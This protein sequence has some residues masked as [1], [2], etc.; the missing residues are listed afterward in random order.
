MSA[1]LNTRKEERKVPTKQRTVTP[2]RLQ[3][4]LLRVWAWDD[5]PCPCPFRPSLSSPVLCP[6]PC[7]SRLLSHLQKDDAPSP[8]T[9]GACLRDNGSLESKHDSNVGQHYQ[10]RATQRRRPAGASAMMTEETKVYRGKSEAGEKLGPNQTWI[11]K[12]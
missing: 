11:R 5:R 12:S 2:L 4:A 7:P 3:L 6:S 9:I 1:R 8:E 10:A